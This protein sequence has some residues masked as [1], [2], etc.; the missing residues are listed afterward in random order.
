MSNL[1][2]EY[3]Q[4]VTS[5]GWRKKLQDVYVFLRQFQMLEKKKSYTILPHSDQ[6]IAV[7]DVNGDEKV[8]IVNTIAANLTTI[9]L[10]RP[11]RLNSDGKVHRVRFVNA[12]KGDLRIVIEDNVIFGR[13]MSDLYLGYRVNNDIMVGG[14]NDDNTGISSWLKEGEQK[15]VCDVRNSTEITI[16]KNDFN[17]YTTLELDTENMNLN[18]SVFET[19]LTDNCIKSKINLSCKIKYKIGIDSTKGD[20]V[21]DLETI[22]RVQHQDGTETLLQPSYARTGNRKKG[23]DNLTGYDYV[24]LK[25]DDKISLMMRKDGFQG[26]LKYVGLSVSGSV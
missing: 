24:D 5:I 23:D 17:N 4:K 13:G 22:I 18:P 7:E 6:S 10:P 25:T 3:T 1:N 2:Q 19:N 26:S 8:F 21:W 9:T 20:P 16:N 15:V 11:N 14:V 12:G